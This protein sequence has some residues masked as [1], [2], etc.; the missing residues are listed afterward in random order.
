MTSN[1]LMIY[2]CNNIDIIICNKLLSQRL[3]YEFDTCHWQEWCQKMSNTHH[4]KTPNIRT[5]I[6][7]KAKEKAKKQNTTKQNT[8]IPHSQTTTINQ[9]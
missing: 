3:F 7:K 5:T 8:K 2:I 6:R 1:L 9:K 4:I